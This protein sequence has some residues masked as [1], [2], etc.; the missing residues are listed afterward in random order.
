M[1]N[2]V[3]KC[4]CSA[5]CLLAED[6]FDR[7]DSATIGGILSEVAGTWD[8]ESNRLKATAA[9]GVVVTAA[10]SATQLVSVTV[11]GSANGQQARIL[12]DYVDTNNYYFAQVQFGPSPHLRIYRRSGGS[13]TQLATTTVTAAIN[14]DY[15]FT[16]CNGSNTTRLCASFNGVS[17]DAAGFSPTTLPVGLGTGTLSSGNV[18][19]DNL[20]ITR[21]NGV[22]DPCECQCV[23]EDEPFD[24]SNGTDTGTKFTEVA[25]SWEITSN[26]VR[27][28]DDDAILACNAYGIGSVYVKVAFRFS[29]TNDQV[30][31]L[32]DYVDAN[33]FLAW[34]LT[35]K[36]GGGN[37]EMRVFRRSGGSDTTLCRYQPSSDSQ[38]P[39]DSGRQMYFCVN[40]DELLWLHGNSISPFHGG[41]RESVSNG[42]VALATG[43]VNGSDDGVFFDS[44]QLLS[45][46]DDDCTFCHPLGTINVNDLNR[47]HGK[48]LPNTVPDEVRVTLNDLGGGSNCGGAC[49]GS[50][51]Y[52]LPMDGT[53]QNSAMTV[54]SDIAWINAAYYMLDTSLGSCSIRVMVAINAIYTSFPTTCSLNGEVRIQRTSTG[55]GTLLWQGITLDSTCAAIDCTILD[56]TGGSLTNSLWPCSSPPSS[57]RVRT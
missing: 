16:F 34:E 1:G 53:A 7:A 44:F 13:D 50:K 25:G 28:K 42:K 11:R 37:F 24:Y 33:N 18:Q 8:I 19:F 14:T 31:V 40:G 49:P 12:L 52:Y 9:S 46:D 23:I 21:T 29:A 3:M 38:F 35:C 51:D 5:T 15:T 39:L 22:C 55:G 36:A 41:I 4:C 43:T 45:V 2:G 26:T 27:T 10:L 54:G 17:L 32:F 47:F 48:C 6:N 56:A 20:T 30:R 57:V